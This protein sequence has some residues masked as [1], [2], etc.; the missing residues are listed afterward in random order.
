MSPHSYH[1]IVKRIYDPSSIEDGYRVLVD[2]LWPR[3]MSKEKANINEWLKEVAPS[4]PLRQS[5]HTTLN[6]EEFEMEYKKELSY[7]SEVLQRI[8]HLLQHQ[9]IC[10]LFSSKDRTHNHA[11]ILREV[12]LDFKNV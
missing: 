1:I 10:L 12:L 5:Y 11:V 9:N 6:F 3:G 2:R 7:Q 4:T 8:L